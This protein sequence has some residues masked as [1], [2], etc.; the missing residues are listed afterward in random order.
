MSDKK[1]N[2]TDQQWQDELSADAFYVCRQKGTEHPFSGEL[3][4][5]KDQGG[6][7]CICCDQLLF[8]SEKKFDSGCGWPSFYQAVDKALIEHQDL[9]H[10]MKR[11]E[12]VCSHCDAHLGHV[13]EDGPEPTG[14]RYC[15]NSVAMTFNKDE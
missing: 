12:V 10:N 15:I 3:N 5:C 7:H 14:L 8:R 6:Y 13:F 2:K 11:V 1:L 9:S 4:D